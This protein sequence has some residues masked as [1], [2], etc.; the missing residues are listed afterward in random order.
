MYENKL[1]VMLLCTNCTIHKYASALI[2]D[3]IQPIKF[4]LQLF[5]WW[6]T[7]YIPVK[8]GINLTA[9]MGIFVCAVEQ[10]WY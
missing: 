1:F 6:D 9:D 5:H 3:I 4:Q 8:Y 7:L 2:G 10:V